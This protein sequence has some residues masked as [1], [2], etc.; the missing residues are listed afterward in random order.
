MRDREIHISQPAVAGF[1]YMASN[2]LTKAIALF[3]TP[4]FTRL[5]A[6]EEFGLYSLYTT[7]LGVL[8][9]LLA[10]GM[11][12]GAIY[13]ALGK[14][15]GHEPELM[16]GA[17]GILIISC[18]AALLVLILFGGRA[19]K[20][21]SLP[22]YILVL[23][24]GE[25]FLNVAESIIFASMR[26]RYIYIR[27]CI[28]NLLYALLSVGVSVLLIYFTPF[29][30]QARIFASFGVSAA[31]ILPE[32]IKH[33]HKKQLYKRQILRYLLRL[34]LPLL[35]YTL[36]MTLIAQSDKIMIEHYSGTGALAK[37][38]VAYSLGF[39]LTSL[40]N[41]LYAALQPW[42]MRKLNTGEGETAKKLVEKIIRLLSFGLV[43]FLLFTPEIF[44]VVATPEYRSAEAAVY[45][46]AI[47]GILQF[48]LNILSSN[49]IHTEKTAVLSLFSILAFGINLGL[50]FIF[51]PT[52]G[53]MAAALTTALSYLGL[54]VLEYMYL[55]RRGEAIAD[56][57]SFTPL[58]LSL[59]ALP[60]YLLRDFAVTRV[61]FSAAVLLA[62]LPC[63]LS[64]LR[65]LPER[66]AGK[67]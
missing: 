40:T 29:R 20:L 62:A 67:T 8:S 30:A 44:T 24:L 42:I 56:I 1:F 6:P 63:A 4:L 64:L 10:L 12:G 19:E 52:Y 36:S 11:S 46:L 61:I 53:Y 2:I 45:P 14:F 50:N 34:A 43:V 5:L 13:R 48:V 38:S 65:E 25:V 32:L 39:M 27:I 57:K 28:I 3:T 35:P 15:R 7:W 54:I 26:Y 16:S 66:S 21:F 33:I 17:F 60:I 37:Y 58:F 22:F 55:K 9:V 18:T 49:I 31:L 51:I 47:A 59:L 41:A 23:L